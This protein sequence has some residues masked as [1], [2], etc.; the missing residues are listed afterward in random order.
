MKLQSVICTA[1]KLTAPSLAK[2]LEATISHTSPPGMEAVK[3]IDALTPPSCLTGMG[4]NTLDW[5]KEEER[6]YK[7]ILVLLDGDGAEYLGLE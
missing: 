5:N 2:S 1:I 4:P 6:R 7:P 3:L